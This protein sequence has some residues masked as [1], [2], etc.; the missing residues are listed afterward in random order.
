MNRKPLEIVSGLALFLFIALLLGWMIILRLP[1][2]PVQLIEWLGGSRD[3]QRALVYFSTLVSATLLILVSFGI[4]IPKLKLFITSERVM[5]YLTGLPLWAL[6]LI[7]AGALIGFW[8]VFPS[9]QPPATV[10]FDVAGRDKTFRPS[11]T[12]TVAP[13]ESLTVTVRPANSG[14]TISCSWEYAGPIFDTPGAQRGCQVNVRFGKQPG[15]GFLTVVTTENF[16]SQ[17][18]IFSLQ[19][20]IPSP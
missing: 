11:E 16:C 18:S 15:S 13:D 7:W 19:A 14:S 3:P 12:L 6:L 8:Y 1:G 5:R 9:C 10:I 2:I 20:V 17:T 4:E